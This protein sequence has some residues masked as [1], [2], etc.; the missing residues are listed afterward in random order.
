MG[1]AFPPRSCLFCCLDHPGSQHSEIN[2]PCCAEVPGSCV[3]GE[4]LTRVLSPTCSLQES[5]LSSHQCIKWHFQLSNMP[6][7]AWLR[8]VQC[9]LYLFRSRRCLTKPT[10]YSWRPV[11]HT[12]LL[13]LFSFRLEPVLSFFC[14]K[15]IT[16]YTLN[17]WVISQL[18]SW[19]NPFL[20]D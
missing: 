19:V 17:E 4:T 11:E 9:H 1:T 20:L 2:I 10:V 13:L 15:Q 3:S 8:Q 6:A 12:L 5:T 14:H 16:I 7:G 18:G